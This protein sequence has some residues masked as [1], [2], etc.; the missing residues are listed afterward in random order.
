MSPSRSNK[1]RNRLGVI[2]CGAWGRNYIRVFG[3]LND[4]D[5]IGICDTQPEQLQLTAARYP[6]VAP[7]QDYQELLKRVD[8][9]VIATPVS[10]QY[11][12][13]REALD[14]GV[15]VLMEKPM[16]TDASQARQ[17]IDLAREHEKI[18]MVGYLF[19]YNPAIVAFKRFLDD[20]EHGVGDIY[21]L[22][23][24]R[25][26]WGPVRT[27]VNVA[28]D[29]ASHDI[30]IFDYLLAEQPISARASGS[31]LLRSSREDVAFIVLEYP[32]R[33]IGHIHVSWLD[34]NKVRQTVV[35]GSQQ[36]ISFDDLNNQEQLKIFQRNDGDQQESAEDFG[37]F[38]LAARN[39]TIVSPKIEVAEP[40]KL[41][42]QAFIDC[43]AQSC[44]PRTDGNLALNVIR[45][46]AAIE[47]SLASDGRA[48]EVGHEN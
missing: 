43:I 32:N 41:Q 35:V 30:A 3:Q 21:Y 17:L 47:K 12:I 1:I 38:L 29:L 48:I 33:I 13:A 14:L 24:T 25:T 15:H 42:C 23:S 7:Y 6:D 28:W 20:P 16:V 8:S 11:M 4:A 36:R 39:E 22:H 10:E 46:L 40:L 5:V 19:L 37:E 45:V 34:P 18:L 26:N 2:G 44:S 31:K 27:D 9:V